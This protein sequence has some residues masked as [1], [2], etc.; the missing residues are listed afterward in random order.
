MKK[1]ILLS[2]IL[3]IAMFLSSCSLGGDILDKLKEGQFF[4]STDSDGNAI[5]GRYSEN[6]Q[7]TANARMDKVLAVIKNKDVNALKAMFSK[8][9]IANTE[10]LDQSIADLFDYFQGDFISYNDW[11]GPLAEETFD[12]GDKQKILCSSYDVVTSE[13]TYRFAIQDFTT[14]TAD[15]DNVG[16][17]SLYIIK[18][19]DDTDPQFGYWGDGKDTP[20]I[21][22]GIK[23]VLPEEAP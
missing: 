20:G 22:I 13:Q 1:R 23:N 14:D 12:Y 21:N 10:N 9:V 15:P 2:L 3:L 8:K 18:M 17:W 11:G 7:E 4:Q 6:D 5:W 19:A 16:I